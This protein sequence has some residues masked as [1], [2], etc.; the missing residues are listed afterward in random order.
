[1]A[2]YPEPAATSIA[3]WTPRPGDEELLRGEVFIDDAQLLTLE[4][5][6]PQY[7]LSLKGNL[8][9][10]CHQLRVRVPSPDKENRIQVEVYSLSKPTEICIQVLAPFTANVPINGLPTGQYAIE[11]NGEDLGAIQIP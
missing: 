3:D 10:P 11:V 5:Y 2:T 8:P 7:M 6:P 4:S 1:L 9:T